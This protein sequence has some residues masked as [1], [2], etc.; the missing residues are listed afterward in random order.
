[1]SAFGVELE[2]DAINGLL[3]RDGYIDEENPPL[4][5]KSMSHFRAQYNLGWR[6]QKNLPNNPVELIAQEKFTK[7]LTISVEQVFLSGRRSADP[8]APDLSKREIAKIVHRLTQS[9]LVTLCE[10]L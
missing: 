8:D 5:V 6:E 1:M 3:E 7:A 10:S 9:A 2:L 4:A